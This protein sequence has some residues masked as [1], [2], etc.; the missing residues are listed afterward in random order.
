MKS[1]YSIYLTWYELSGK[2]AVVVCKTKL[3]FLWFSWMFAREGL[4]IIENDENCRFWVLLKF[5]FEKQI[6]TT[7]N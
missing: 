7:K 6:S 2:K 4:I 3:Y 1:K 5:L